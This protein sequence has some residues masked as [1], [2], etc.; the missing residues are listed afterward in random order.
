MR[1]VR[2]HEPCS[3]T[4]APV[5]TDAGTAVAC[6]KVS[7]SGAEC[8]WMP[9]SIRSAVAQSAFGPSGLV[10][11]SRSNGMSRLPAGVSWVG[12]QNGQP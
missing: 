2:F 8:A 1:R 4:A 12:L 5:R 6:R 9:V 10:C 11:T 7:P 3:A